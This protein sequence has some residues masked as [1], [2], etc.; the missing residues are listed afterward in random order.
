[1]VGHDHHSGVSQVV[2]VLVLF[3][4][5]KAQDFDD[6]GNLGVLH[7]LFRVHVLHIQQLAPQR[8]YSKVIPPQFLNSTQSEGFGRVAL[9]QN[10]AAFVASS[11]LVGVFQLGDDKSIFLCFL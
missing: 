2:C 11:S 7:G 3:A 5:G 1:M 9:S 6:V 10:K 8:K 4:E